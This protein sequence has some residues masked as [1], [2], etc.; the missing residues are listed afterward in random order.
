MEVV[1]VGSGAVSVTL[2]LFIRSVHKVTIIAR[3]E[4]RRA[5]IASAGIE[6]V[7]RVRG[8]EETVFPRVISA[9]EVLKGNA[10]SA[11]VVFIAVKAYDLEGALEVAKRIPGKPCIVTLQNGV[12]PYERSLGIFGEKAVHG[13]V[14][15]GAYRPSLNK[16]VIV[17]HGKILVGSAFGRCNCV[18]K[19]LECL[20]T[21]GIDALYVDNVRGWL[22]VKLLVNA[23]INPITALL[24]APN[25]IIL[26]EPIRSL[27]MMI[28]EEGVEVAKRLGIELPEDPRSVTLRIADE[29]KENLSSMLQDIVSCR[30]TEIDY[31]NG[32]IARYAEQLGIDAK[33]NKAMYALVKALELR[34][35]S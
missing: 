3:N 33:L 5:E 7:D 23:A 24:R 11:D 25:G 30:R 13:I 8:I 22:W 2:Y 14:T 32:A 35:S 17:S 34:C 15:F 18:D 16:V 19:V 27:A 10:P 28:I 6:V 4:K 12:E 29:T 1:L 31:I 21:P 20:R 26:T 9:E